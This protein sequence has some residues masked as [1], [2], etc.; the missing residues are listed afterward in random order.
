MKGPTKKEPSQDLQV[1][2]KKPRKAKMVYNARDVIKYN[3]REL[4]DGEIALKSNDNRYLGGYQKAVTAVLEGM[5]DE[6]REEIQNTVDL[7]NEE[8]GPSDLRLKF[9]LNISTFGCFFIF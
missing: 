7:W 1:D 6:D 9:V 4:I 3:H 2:V 8:G 5:N